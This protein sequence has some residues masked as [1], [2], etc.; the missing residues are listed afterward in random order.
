MKE[1]EAKFLEID[2]DNIIAK[3]ESLG[4]RKTFEGEII[5]S[6]FDTRKRHLKRKGLILRLRRRGQGSEITLKRRISA[7]G[8]KV[9]E[10]HESTVSDFEET[11]LI[12]GAL[13][14]VETVKRAKHRITYAIGETHFEIDTIAGMPPFLEIEAPGVEEIRKAAE[15]LG[16]DMKGAKTWSEGDV[17]RYY[18][19]K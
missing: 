16:I 13:G 9:M 14:Y 8:A 6:Y 2:K 1:I 4:A 3:L 11:K 15:S 18:A 7:I 5:A 17:R 10:E 12:L 19:R